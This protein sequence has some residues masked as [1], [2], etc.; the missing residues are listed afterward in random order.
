LKNALI[1]ASYKEV[2]AL[3]I[4]LK[5]LVE[6]LDESDVV[7]IADDSPTEFRTRLQNDCESVF[8][9]SKSSFLL[10]FGETKSGRGNAVRRGMGMALDKYPEI[11]FVIEMDADSSHQPADIQ[12]VRNSISEADL[13][14]GSRYLKASKIIGWP[15]SRRIFSRTLNL[16]IPRLLGI[17]VKDITNG[18]RRY[19]TRSAELFLAAEPKNSGFTYL[20]EQ[21]LILHR[22]GCLIEEVP[23]TFVNR[24]I[25][26]STVT[27]KEIISSL[28]GIFQLVKSNR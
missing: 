22:A 23:T 1:I 5:E 19:K 10:S 16:L 14:I 3:P 20:S 27:Y 9:N 8:Q 12:N 26:K 24:T 13:I 17:D 18:L 21:A 11:K 25:G 28:R 4:L 15:L 2:D 7:V 6:F